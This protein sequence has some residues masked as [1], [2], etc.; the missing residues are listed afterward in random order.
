MAG[1]GCF[2]YEFVDGSGPWA[3]G[4]YVSGITPDSRGVTDQAWLSAYQELEA[5]NPGTYSVAGYSAML[6]LAEGVKKAGSLDA[7]AVAAALRGM[8]I[9]SP[10]GTIS[11]DDRGDM[12]QQQIYIFQ[13]RDGE[14]QQ[15]KPAVP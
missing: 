3:E 9:K 10:M 7:D 11:Y 6:V 4:V 14:F 8:E 2:L 13:V 12:Q 1:D 5:R 15:V